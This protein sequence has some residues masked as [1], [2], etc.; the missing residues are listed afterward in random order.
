MTVY[1]VKQG[2]CLETIAP[3]Y[4][5]TAQA[6]WDAPENAA[7]AEERG[8]LNCLQPGDRLE[9]PTPRQREESVPTDG[10]GRFRISRPRSRLRVRLLMGN[11]PRA[12][13]AYRLEYDTG[14]QH[15]GSTDGDGWVDQPLPLATRQ[16][17]LYLCDDQEVHELAVGSLDP[18]TSTT[19]AQAR[20]ANL[21]HYFGE[22][23]DTLGPA[24]Q[25]AL[26]R[27][28]AARGLDVTGE[29]DDATADAL[30]SDHDA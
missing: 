12:G 21:G 23:D 6:L 1:V 24:T 28:Q 2:D 29:L 10:K 13:E 18:P 19:G 27:F 5:W 30:R 14:E 8:D 7:L 4:G 16:A 9:I 20:L 3:R 15:E 22:V 17:T 26:R 11:D 25:A